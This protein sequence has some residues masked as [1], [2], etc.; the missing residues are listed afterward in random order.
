LSRFAIGLAGTPATVSPGRTLLVTIEPAP[1][2]LSR[3]ISRCCL[4]VQPAPTLMV[5]HDVAEQRDKR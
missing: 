1:I 2:M 4:I 5:S 3:P